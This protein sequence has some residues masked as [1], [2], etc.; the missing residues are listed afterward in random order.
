MESRLPFVADLM[1]IAEA[2]PNTTLRSKTVRKLKAAA[3]TQW[4]LGDIRDAIAAISTLLERS[5][6]GGCLEEPAELI[7]NRSLLT[8][9]LSLYARAT[10][11]DGRGAE[12]GHI[13]L[14]NLYPVE[15]MK[16]AHDR[17]IADR[18]QAIAHVDETHTSNGQVWYERALLLVQHPQGWVAF[19]FVQT[20][21]VHAQSANDLNNI[22]PTAFSILENMLER[23]L[24]EASDMM[25]ELPEEVLDPIIFSKGFDVVGFFGTSERAYSALVHPTRRATATGNSVR[26][27]TTTWHK[28]D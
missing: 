10:H 13:K 15:E 23:L 25:L 6:D 1:A 22:L 7:I 28:P 11:T 20:V 26:P 2:L 24:T 3:K 4:C 18:N 9:A 17:V 21:G 19:P 14:R 16:L 8:T 5:N 12:R 27:A